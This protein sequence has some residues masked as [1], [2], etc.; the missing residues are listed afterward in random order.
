MD[1][2]FA[3]GR[4]RKLQ[5]LEMAG[6]LG[7]DM[8]TMAVAHGALP[9]IART[10]N[11]TSV[12]ETRSLPSVPPVAADRV[13][14]ETMWRLRWRAA[15][16]TAALAVAVACSSLGMTYLRTRSTDE[17]TAMAAVPSPLG[18]AG[19]LSVA[20]ERA[21]SPTPSPAAPAAE[22]NNCGPE[23]GTYILEVV[24]ASDGDPPRMVL[25]AVARDTIRP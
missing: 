9:P 15:A 17:G 10:T 19:V 24:P 20:P 18:R 1:A 6:Q 2:L 11:E 23:R 14:S 21:P 3:G 4:A 5:L 16:T 22:A 25:R 13:S 8:P 12:V 7:G